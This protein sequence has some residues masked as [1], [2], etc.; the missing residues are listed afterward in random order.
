MNEPHDG[1]ACKKD[2]FF[3]AGFE[4]PGQY[5]QLQGQ[6]IPLSRAICC[7]PCL[8]AGSISLPGI[9][10][11]VS[12]NDVIAI[13]SDCQVS[14]KNT[15]GSSIQGQ[16]CPADS[17][18]QGFQHD[19]RANPRSSRSDQYYYPVD[20]A[21]CCS[22]RLLLRTGGT[23]GGNEL[24]VDRCQCAEQSAP[25]A[26]G[27][28]AA[29]TPEA[30]AAAGALLYA[31]DN[32]VTAVGQY[33][34]PLKVPVTPIRCCK[35]CVSPN[36]KPAMEDCASLNFCR[37][38]GDCTIDGHCECKAGWV[39][40]D[41]GRVDGDGD[42]V[43][44]MMLTALK[45]AAGILLG[46]CARYPIMR[47]L[48]LSRRQGQAGELEQALLAADGTGQGNARENDFDF[49]ASD[50]STS[51]DSG[52]ED[53]DGNEETDVEEDV[54]VEEAGTADADESGAGG[55]SEEGRDD[56]EVQ[57]PGTE[58]ED[59]A[60]SMVSRA[61]GREEELKD[62]ATFDVDGSETVHG[63]NGSCT[64]GLGRGGRGPKVECSVCM[65]ARVQVVLVPCGHACMCRKCSRRLRRCPIC[66][67][68]VER[69]QKLYMGG[70]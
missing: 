29:N 30:A 49:E 23:D 70:E 50:L 5:G 42:T 60:G 53:E 44:Q 40:S 7:R 54:T 3:I 4:T 14:A 65:S 10:G 12:A 2:G 43:H 64:G 18:V 25:Y 37:G 27:C 68:I 66:R 24:P 19:V 38:N 6:Y 59:A 46:C 41:C 34:Q 63:N 32:E 1:L 52:G 61:G 56:D 45:V 22:P 11:N 33:G 31:F 21:Q 67:T 57:E 20:A 15:D 9:S 28:G 16:A 26:V 47:C 51:D 58:A 35:A 13:S 39:G 8:P 17:F 62:V 48:G 69:R 55:E 36:A